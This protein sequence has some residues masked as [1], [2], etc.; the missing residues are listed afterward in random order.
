MKAN[1]F[2]YYY[3]QTLLNDSNLPE[4]VY[5]SKNNYKFLDKKKAID[6]LDAEKKI[7]PDVK[8]RLVTLSEKYSTEEWK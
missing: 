1:T 6:L 4:I 3:V 7:T 2:T 5:H 8:F